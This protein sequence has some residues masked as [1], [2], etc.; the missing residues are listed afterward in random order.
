MYERIESRLV[1]SENV[2]TQA[3]VLMHGFGS[4][5][6]NYFFFHKLKADT[7]VD[8]MMLI[9]N[10]EIRALKTCLLVKSLSLRHKLNFHFWA[11]IR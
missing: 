9:T 7:L 8:S 4:H 11:P 1:W 3:V 2:L 6:K 5:R 10:I